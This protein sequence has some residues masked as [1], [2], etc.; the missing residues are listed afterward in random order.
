MSLFEV[1]KTSTF[2]SVVQT[3]MLGRK[4]KAQYVKLLKDNLENIQSTYQEN[5]PLAEPTESLVKMIIGLDIDVTL[6]IETLGQFLENPEKYK[7]YK[8][9]Y[10]FDTK[11]ISL[12]E[13][14]IKY[15]LIKYCEHLHLKSNKE[16][17][18]NSKEFASNSL[19]FNLNK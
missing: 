4:L 11:L 6:L 10:A 13:S 14:E 5:L 17:R 1:K 18:N 3:V 19:L 2:K 9:T 15:L 7:D 8:I 16:L 12:L